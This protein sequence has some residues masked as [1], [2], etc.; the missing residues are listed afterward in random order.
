MT[1]VC[2]DVNSNALPMDGEWKE[3]KTPKSQIYL[4]WKN[5]SNF[6][7]AHPVGNGFGSVA[8]NP[9]DLKNDWLE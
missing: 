3:G 7:C 5:W 1:L 4:Q 6:F 8:S 9:R 2:Y